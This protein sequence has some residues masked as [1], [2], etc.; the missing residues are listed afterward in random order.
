MFWAGVLVPPPDVVADGLAL[1]G[2]GSVVGAVERGLAQG[3]GLGL[4]S[5]Q[6]GGVGRQ[7]HRLDVVGRAPGED[8]VSLVWAEVV[9]DQVE[10]A[11]GSVAVRLPT[12]ARTSAAD[13]SRLVSAVRRTADLEFCGPLTLK[14][15]SQDAA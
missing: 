4:D 13:W 10:A 11:F 6:P 9:D 3:G 8:F 5:V 1:I 12:R 14:S 15:Q 2:V 7:E